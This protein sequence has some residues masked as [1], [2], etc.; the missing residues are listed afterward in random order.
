MLQ[1]PDV[2]ICVV[3]LVEQSCGIIVDVVT[4]TSGRNKP[5]CCAQ[6]APGRAGS[7]D[8]AAFAS[9]SSSVCN[10]CL[11]ELP[12]ELMHVIGSCLHRF[13]ITCL[14]KYL[15]EKLAGRT[16]PMVCPQ[17]GCKHQIAMPECRLLLQ[18][19]E[20]A[21]KLAEV[22]H[23]AAGLLQSEAAHCFAQ[24]HCKRSAA[25]LQPDHACHVMMLHAFA[26]FL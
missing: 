6:A 7:E 11:E 20:A 4:T 10:I 19:Q 8:L 17:P 25:I 3:R 9:S 12:A 18:S 5:S 23:K 26:D 16:Y 2:A 1:L 15:R 21:D 14:A 24:H 13:C 22:C